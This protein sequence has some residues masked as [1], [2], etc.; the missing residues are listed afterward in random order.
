MVGGTLDPSDD[1]GSAR[2]I[3]L[4]LDTQVNFSLIQVLDHELRLFR[5]LE[6][7]KESCKDSTNL[8]KALRFIDRKRVDGVEKKQLLR[9]LNSNIDESNLKLAEMNNVYRRL[10]LK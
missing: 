5:E 10:G 1:F 7:I 2:N 9:F 6:S 3:V 8:L 4:Q